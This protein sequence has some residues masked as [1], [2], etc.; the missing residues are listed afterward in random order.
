MTV[1]HDRRDLY[2][3]EQMSQCCV[4]GSDC[5]QVCMVQ[6]RNVADLEKTAPKKK[7]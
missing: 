6:R 1:V 4:I 7:T 2:T 5:H 3:K